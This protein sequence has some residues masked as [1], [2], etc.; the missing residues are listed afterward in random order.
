M[1]DIKTRDGKTLTAEHF[2]N[3]QK[4]QTKAELDAKYSSAF[5]KENEKRLQRIRATSLAKRLQH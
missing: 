1:A 3:D 5:V 2:E 4:P